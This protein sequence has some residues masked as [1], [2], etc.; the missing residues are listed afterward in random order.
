[1]CIN[2]NKDIYKKKIGNA[3][4]DKGGLGMIEVVSAYTGKNIRP[5]FFWGKL[6]IDSIWA[7]PDVTI[8]N[9]CIMPAGYGI[10]YHHLFVI[11]IHTSLHI[12]TI[13]PRVRRAAPRRLNTFLPYIAIKNTRA[14]KETFGDIA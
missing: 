7:T 1:V 2:A 3:L 8:S 4:T 5:T 10:G 14:L 9:L 6:Q 11:D 12:G 13:P